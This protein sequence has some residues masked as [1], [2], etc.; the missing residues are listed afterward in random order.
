M[1][2]ALPAIIN[3]LVLILLEPSHSARVASQFF[4]HIIETILNSFGLWLSG[5]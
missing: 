2:S 4:F 1:D 3:D 5:G